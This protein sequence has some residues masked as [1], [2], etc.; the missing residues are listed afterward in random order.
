VQQKQL[1]R[2]LVEWVVEVVVELLEE[3][4]VEV[5]KLVVVV[6]ILVVAVGILVVVVGIQA[7][8]V[9]KLVAGVENFGILAVGE[10][11]LVELEQQ[12][13]LLWVLGLGEVVI[14]VEQ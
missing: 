13:E 7:V 12:L 3:I 2:I 11:L 5:G 8:G 4:V 1:L 14:L 6:G 9:G 10:K